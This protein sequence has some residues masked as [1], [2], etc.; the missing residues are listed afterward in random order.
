[1]PV[2]VRELLPFEIMKEPWNE[3]VI[4]DEGHD[5]TLRGRLILAKVVRIVDKTDP[6]RH[7]VQVAP[8]QIWITHSPQGLR[9]EPSPTLP[10]PADIP[11][12]EKRFV[13]VETTKESWNV[14]R[15]TE[16]KVD[17]RLRTVVSRVYRVPGVFAMDGEPYYIVE[18]AGLSEFLK[19]GKPAGTLVGEI[20]H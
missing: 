13:E 11:D 10:S 9:G 17:L 16:D 18:S 15:L 19:E 12:D 4:K 6:K 7:G 5:V 3:Y 20:T 14:Y 8:H 1:M 2:E